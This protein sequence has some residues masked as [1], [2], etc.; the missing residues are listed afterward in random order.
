MLFKF[1]LFRNGIW[2]NDLKYKIV[3]EIFKKKDL[4]KIFY[5]AYNY[6]IATYI[7]GLPFYQSGNF[8]IAITISFYSIKTS[9]LLISS[10][11]HK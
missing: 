4:G 3:E 7:D 11:G 2:K 8:K 5:Y 6:K 1:L 9:L 10:L